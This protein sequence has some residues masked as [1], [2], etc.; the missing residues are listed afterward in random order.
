MWERMGIVTLLPFLLKDKALAMS[1]TSLLSIWV[2]LFKFVLRE[3]E[4]AGAGGA[5]S[6]GER[7]NPKQA[8]HCQHR[9]WCGA[10]THTP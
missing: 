8:P 7:E 3:R 2:F 4:H 1:A 5:E 10:R 9:A 6:E